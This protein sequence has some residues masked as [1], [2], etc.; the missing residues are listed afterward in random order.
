LGLIR[1]SDSEISS[2]ILFV[3]KKYGGMRLCID[4]LE[5]N[6][7]IFYDAYTLPRIDTLLESLSGL[8]FFTKMDLRDAYNQ[9]RMDKASEKLPTFSCKNGNYFFCVLPFGLACAPGIFKHFINNILQKFI[10]KKQILCYLDDIMIASIDLHENRE[11]PK[12]VIE[13][14][15]QNR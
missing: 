2:P 1:P 15:Q 12:E 10:R 14:L 5:F 3:K 13:T 8:C 4:F 11:I 7:H 9:L 6:S